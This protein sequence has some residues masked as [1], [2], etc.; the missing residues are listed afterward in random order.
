MI[1]APAGI[2][3][4]LAA[5]PQTQYIANLFTFNLKMGDSYYFTDAPRPITIGGITYSAGT[6]IQR[7]KVK[8]SRGL[9]VDSHQITIIEKNGAFLDRIMLGYFN[10]ATYTMARVFASSASSPWMGPV[11]RFSGQ[12]ASIEEIGRG[13]AKLTAKSML[14]ILDNDFPRILLQNDCPHVLFDSGCGLSRA[15]YLVAGTV[16]AGST[17]NTILSD[18]TSKPDGWFGQGVITFLSGELR[19]FSYMVRASAATGNL[20]PAYPLM[21]VPAAGDTFQVSPGC[22]KTLATCQSKFGLDLTSTHAPYFAGTPFIPDPTTV[23]G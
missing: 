17:A 12:V 23:Y 18:V 20:Y 21:A 15:D 8:I 16:K 11:V 10:L 19:G 1:D 9:S 14:N 13:S 6:K 7:G 2:A 22:D 3:A 5:R 4:L